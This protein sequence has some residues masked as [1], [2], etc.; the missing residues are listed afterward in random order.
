LSHLRR[1]IPTFTL[2]VA[3]ASLYLYHL[4]AVGVLDPDE[5]RY[6][7]IGRAMAK[8]G[9]YVTPRL[10]GAPWFEKPP[11]LYWMAALGTLT[12]FGPESSGRLPVALLSLGFLLL[13]FALLRCEFGV[14]ASAV[15]TALLATSAGWLAYSDLALTDLPMAA[16]FSTAAFLTLP[17]LRASEVN[18]EGRV[19][20]HTTRFLLIGLSLG[21]ASLAKGL[22]PVALATPFFWFLRHY[23]RSWWLAI[24]ACLAVAL[25]WYLAV[26]VRNGR[27]FLDEFFWRHHF[28]RL[29]SASLQHVQPPY[30]YVPVFLAALFPWTPLLP[31]LVLRRKPWDRRAQFLASCF[32]FGFVIFSSSLN[33]L[34]GYLLP[35]L[36]LGFA[37][38]GTSV[39]WKELRSF[40]WW[41][42]PCA[43]LVGMIPL[44][45]RALPEAL[46]VGHITLPGLFHIGRTAYFYM[47]API[48]AILFAKRRWAG[49]LLILCIATGGIYLKIT[50][51]PVLER[52]VSA[53]G[54]WKRVKDAPG[55]VCNNWLERHWDYGLALYRGMPYPRCDSGTFQ[56]A[57]EPRGHNMPVLVRRKQP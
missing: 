49:I 11:L 7:A 47:V 14:E 48:A 16:L 15:S 30:Y 51:F 53:R 3:I 12:G 13:M 26:Y 46:E 25:P 50:S 4:S 44:L 37:L 31:L 55:T 17:L 40:R 28:E 10:W 5:P 8:S 39:E 23:W 20:Q 18:G 29:Y 52:T 41:L 43:V 38:V 56:F 6:L 36:P 22:V 45:A 42:F 33:K 24:A 32:L 2:V 21:L 57:L 1:Y 19:G 27:A 34:P 35:L 9:D 54:L